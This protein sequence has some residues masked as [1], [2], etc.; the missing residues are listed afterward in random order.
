[1]RQQRREGQLGSEHETTDGGEIR[2][3]RRNDPVTDV[4]LEADQ[5]GHPGHHAGEREALLAR[6]DRGV[7]ETDA[8]D[9]GGPGRGHVRR[10]RSRDELP[11]RHAHQGRDARL[12]AG[13][14]AAASGQGPGEEE[15]RAPALQKLISPRMITVFDRRLTGF[16]S[17]SRP[18]WLRLT[19]Y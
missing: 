3:G 1:G 8:A 14:G 18:L 2:D 12:R 6:V 17:R 5:R 16:P 7:V 10:Q 15:Y 9:A 19:S 4:V 11:A 13:A